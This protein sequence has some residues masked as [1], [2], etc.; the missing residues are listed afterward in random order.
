MRTPPDKLAKRQHGLEAA[1][2]EDAGALRGVSLGPC[3]SCD[4]E[5]LVTIA[6]DPRT[7]REAS[8]I[9]HPVPF[10]TYFGETSPEEIERM[11]RKAK[12]PRGTS[13]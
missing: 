4:A 9:M 1:A 10:C 7:G 12:Q 13:R 2:G 11:I 6:R 5:L 8:A 3:P